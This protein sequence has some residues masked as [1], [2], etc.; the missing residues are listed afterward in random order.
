MTNNI[1]Q[2]PLALP[3]PTVW[4]RKMFS[5]RTHTTSE[6][7]EGVSWREDARTCHCTIIGFRNISRIFNKKTE[8][9]WNASNTH[10]I[11][12][13][14]PLPAR[15]YYTCPLAVPSH[16]LKNSHL[17]SRQKE[18]KKRNKTRRN[19]KRISLGIWASMTFAWLRFG[20]SWLGLACSGLS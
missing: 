20:L 15:N 8:N 3:C 11:I 5:P 13:A 4:K 17:T 14:H 18:E 1:W 2:L 7:V 16:L 6:R 19:G 9:R 12:A 10:N